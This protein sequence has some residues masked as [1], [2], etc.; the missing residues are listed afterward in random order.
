[1]REEISLAET[2]ERQ[3]HWLRQMREGISLAET[4]ERGDIIG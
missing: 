2:D 1:M 4:D 3:H